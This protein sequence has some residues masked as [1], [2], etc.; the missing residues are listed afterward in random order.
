MRFKTDDNQDIV[1]EK[2]NNFCRD[3]S[4][5][6]LIKIDIKKLSGWKSW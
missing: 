3:N 4:K 1:I 2:F 5:A 6:E